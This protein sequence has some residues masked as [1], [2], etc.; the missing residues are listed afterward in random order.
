[1]PS[2]HLTLRV[3][4][5]LF[6]EL[7]AESRR[8][9]RTRSEVAKWLLEEGL[10]MARHPGIIFRP[11]PVGRRPGLVH[12]PDVWEVARVLKG[13]ESVEAALAYVA[14][15]M[16]LSL[17]QAQAAWKYYAEFRDE[18]DAWMKRVDDEADRAEA[19]W[20]REQQLLPR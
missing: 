17:E 10:R 20:L 9:G 13:H 14:D 3:D 12:G 16:D 8:T 1:M 4:E 15:S 11:G 5:N 6:E 18:I 2:R 7:E 19:A